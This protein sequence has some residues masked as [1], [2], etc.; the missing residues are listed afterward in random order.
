MV[1]M[2]AKAAQQRE[3]AA[4]VV[5]RDL[6]FTYPGARTPVLDGV[7]LEARAGSVTCLM[8]VNG[9]GKSTLIDCIL[10]VNHIDGGHILIDGCD[11]SGLRPAQLAL[12]CAYVPQAHERAFPFRVRDIVLMGRTAH[13]SFLGSPGDEDRELV[14]AALAECGIAHLADRPYTQLSGGEMQM[15]MLAR[16]LAQ[17]TPFIFMDEPTA[18]LDFKNELFFMETVVRLVREQGVGVLMATHSPNQAF[19][20]EG[21]G[22]P[23]LCAL[24]DGGRVHLHGTPSQVLT[25]DNLSNYYGVRAQV[26]GADVGQGRHLD[27]ILQISTEGDEDDR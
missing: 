2:D 3:Q 19:F 9:C 13:Q 7:S 14:E 12:K 11:A 25:P 21:N 24:M 20:F 27:Q 26:V 10:G 5:V 22:V 17:R 15:V 8:G 23:V 6:R 1:T 4:F 16:A 18:H